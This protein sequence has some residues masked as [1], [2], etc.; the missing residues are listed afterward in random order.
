MNAQGV[1]RMLGL[2]AG[3]E[4]PEV[5]LDQ[6]L[7]GILDAVQGDAALVALSEEGGTLSFKAAKGR[8]PAA[9]EA[10]KR[11]ALKSQRLHLDQG[12][13]G[14]VMRGGEGVVVTDAAAEP[15]FKHDIAKEV[16]Y[17]VR[18][19][20]AVPL[21]SGTRRLGVLE[22]LN[23]QPEGAF[24]PDDF[25]TAKAL[26][27]LVSLF[28]EHAW[29]R[30]SLEKK[31][32]ELTML[33]RA[34]EL[35][36]PPKQPGVPPPD[37]HEVLDK[38]VPMA[39]SLTNAEGSA[40]ALLD[41]GAKAEEARIF[42]IAAAGSKKDEIKRVPMKPGEGIVG[43]VIAKGETALVQDVSRDQRFSPKVDQFADHE[44]KSLAAAPVRVGSRIVGAVEVVNK[45]FGESFTADDVTLLKGI[46]QLAGITLE[47][48]RAVA[49]P[50]PAPPRSAK[51][52]AP[53]GTL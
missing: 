28:I 12:V 5:V 39:C 47:I 13:A 2:A 42:F 18:N 4:A 29:I 30:K 22:I 23:K 6:M 7:L 43:W 25:E 10:Q 52:S 21:V 40:V 16:G 36:R 34:L 45:K 15:H 32:V 11:A 38:L 27:A 49:A 37:A 41:P 14:L 8:M 48:A 50:A 1:L 53:D 19:L 46:A 51:P 9:E 3:A 31:A 35:A 24:S 33:L 20:M 17:P 26:A 44:T